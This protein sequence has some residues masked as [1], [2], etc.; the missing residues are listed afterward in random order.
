M[1]KTLKYIACLGGILL[2]MILHGCSEEVLDNPSSDKTLLNLYA[3]T[4][5]TA[6]TRL[7]ELPNTEKIN[8]L[9]DGKQ[10]IGLY[11]Y[12]EDD[13]NK[14]NLT[15]PYIRNLECKIVNSKIVPVDGSSIYIYD[16][17]TIVAFYPYNKSIK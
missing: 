3:A 16:R 10:N 9:V 2:S 5:Q 17:M 13:Y 6:T 14:D 4:A 7:A 15:K 1:N 11:I 8:D 12:Y